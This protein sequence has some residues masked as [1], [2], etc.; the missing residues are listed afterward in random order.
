MQRIV[1]DLPHLFQQPLLRN[2]GELRYIPPHVLH[3]DGNFIGVLLILHGCGFH[4]GVKNG[5]LAGKMIVKRWRFDTHRA[6][7]LPH[8]YR[9]IAL[10]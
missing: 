6:C 1:K 5:L 3:M 2:G 7:N 4:N 9:V 10:L 8:A